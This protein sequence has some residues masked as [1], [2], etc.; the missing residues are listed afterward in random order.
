MSSVW[1]EWGKAT[2]MKIRQLGDKP[3]QG[4]GPWAL[5]RPQRNS[6]FCT[7]AQ[8][9]CPEDSVGFSQRKFWKGC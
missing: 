5:V 4:P 1:P 8:P 3:Q 2:S 9:G 6:R 7:V